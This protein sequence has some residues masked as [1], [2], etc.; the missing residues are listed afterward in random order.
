MDSHERE[1]TPNEMEVLRSLVNNKVDNKFI[2]AYIDLKI[3]SIY[4]H[5]IDARE[6]RVYDVSQ[7]TLNLFVHPVG[8]PG[9]RKC[10]SPFSNEVTNL[11]FKL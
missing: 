8:Y 2:S 5:P 4:E 1:L 6:L 10:I 9:L 7:S 3:N 11:R